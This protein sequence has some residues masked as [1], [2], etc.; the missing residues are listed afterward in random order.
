M[1]HRATW[2][3]WYNL[4]VWRKRSRRQRR[5]QPLCR[6]CLANGLVVPATVA[7]HIEPHKGDWEAFLGGALQSLC[8]ECHNTRKKADENRGYSRE[9]GPDGWPIDPKHPANV[10]K[11]IGGARVRFDPGGRYP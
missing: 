10:V 3:Q 2:N 5:E 9:L 8:F 1:K 11:P 7:D 6:M 4:E